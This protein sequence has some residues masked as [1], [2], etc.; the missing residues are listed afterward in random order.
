MTKGIRSWTRPVAVVG[1]ASLLLTMVSSG[2]MAQ[3]SSTEGDE[4]PGATTVPG[5][6]ANEP[7]RIAV[8]FPNAGDPYFQQKRGNEMAVTVRVP[9]SLKSWFGGSDE[10]LC[11]GGTLGECIADL[12]RSFP[13]IRD[14]LLNEEGEIGAILI[15]LNGENVTKL[16][17]LASR[18][19]DGD[20][21]GII[22][23]AAGG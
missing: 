11:Q 1:A 15:F 3:D 8:L 12:D 17:G 22:P 14:R 23:F 10:V 13:G 18:I 16:E 21:I 19:G 4:V 20:E 9:G 2:V 7:Y 5:L 6:M